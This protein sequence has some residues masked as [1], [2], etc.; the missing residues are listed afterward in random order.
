MIDHFKIF[1]T[2]LIE[3][4]WFNVNR[5]TIND[6]TKERSYHNKEYNQWAPVVIRNLQSKWKEKK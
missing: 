4:K 3:L 1:L 6:K 5:E 2:K